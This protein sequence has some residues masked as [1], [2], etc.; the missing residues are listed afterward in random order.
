[1][2]LYFFFYFVFYFYLGIEGLWCCCIC[3]FFGKNS[4]IPFQIWSWWFG[5]IFSEVVWDKAVLRIYMTGRHLLQSLWKVTLWYFHYF[6]LG[7]NN[8][9]PHLLV[10]TLKF[11]TNQWTKVLLSLQ[12]WNSHHIWLRSFLVHFPSYLLLWRDNG[13]TERKWLCCSDRITMFYLTEPIIT[14][15]VVMKA[16]LSVAHLN[17]SHSEKSGKAASWAATAAL[18][19]LK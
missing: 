9:F 18:M 13:E 4:M 17:K 15:I 3:S 11:S 14:V 1:M 2:L 10:W 16:Q 19:W 12:T 8:S 5:L 7:I 6:Y